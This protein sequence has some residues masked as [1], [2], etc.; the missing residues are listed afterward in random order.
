MLRARSVYAD[1]LTKKLP[2][3][4]KIVGT[5]IDRIREQIQFLFQFKGVWPIGDVNLTKS[6][7]EALLNNE[8][9]YN[10]AT[11]VIEKASEYI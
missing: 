8:K 11:T 7:Q 5:L 6:A 2:E 3:L 4:E 9:L 10:A 1:K